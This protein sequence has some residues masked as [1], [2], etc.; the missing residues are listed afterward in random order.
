MWVYIFLQIVVLCGLVCEQKVCPVYSPKARGFGAFLFVVVLG[1]VVG[2][3]DM[4]GGYDVC[5]YANVFENLAQEQIFSWEMFFSLSNENRTMGMEPGW[6]LYNVLIGKLTSSTYAFFF[7]TSLLSYLA[8]Y[9]HLRKYAPYFFFALLIIFCRQY[10]QS[11]I[12]VRQF[13]A[14]MVAWF[15]LDFA[16]KRKLFPFLVIVFVATNIHTCGL[17][18]LFVY[19]ISRWRMPIWVMIGGISVALVLGLTPVFGA[20]LNSLGGLIGNEKAIGY[21]EGTGGGAHLFYAIEGLLMAVA[22]LM[23][24]PSI[25][26]ASHRERY[27]QQFSK[28][29]KYIPKVS[30]EST[31]QTVCL[32][33][34]MYLYVCASLTTLQSPGM[35]RL[36]WVFWIGPI[37]MLPYICERMVA[38]NGKNLFKFLVVVYFVTAF[39]LFACRFDNGELLD[40]KTFLFVFA[41]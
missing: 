6:I 26:G 34:V 40:Y 10:L 33:N 18:F 13:M 37:C 4:M 12:Y 28:L 25:Y 20:L 1:L 32:F 19:P 15:A 24:R 17:I 36:I 14:C 21:S 5:V 7:I 8:L 39:W 31:A 22:M 30:A 38:G 2:L 29:E 3:R 41:R 27:M 16:I 23:A 35:M 11:F 9:R